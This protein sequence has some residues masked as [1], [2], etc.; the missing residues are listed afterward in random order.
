MNK[1]YGILNSVK[2]DSLKVNIEK[3]EELLRNWG[4][5]AKLSGEDITALKRENAELKKNYKDLKQTFLSSVPNPKEDDLKS[6]VVFCYKKME[7]GSSVVA[8]QLLK[9][10]LIYEEQ[11][12]LLKQEKAHMFESMMKANKAALDHINILYS[13]AVEKCS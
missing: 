8:Q 3:V 13:I 12:N 10:V 5:L 7:G 11:N 1:I 6:Q 2:N 4:A 9:K